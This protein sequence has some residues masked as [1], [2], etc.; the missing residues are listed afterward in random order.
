MMFSKEILSS[1]TSGDLTVAAGCMIQL[2]CPIGN[3]N[4][5]HATSSNRGRLE[6][7]I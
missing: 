2:L 4:Q 6:R 5:D 1:K 7:I 3:G